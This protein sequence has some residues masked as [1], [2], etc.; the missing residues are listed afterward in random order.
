[1][2]VLKEILFEWVKA[3]NVVLMF[4]FVTEI[5]EPHYQHK[6][7]STCVTHCACIN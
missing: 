4:Q 1:M 2:N 7:L 5:L 6:L 3:Y